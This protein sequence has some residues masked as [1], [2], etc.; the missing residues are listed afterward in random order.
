LLPATV[1]SSSSP[2][3]VGAVSCVPL[4]GRRD[5]S[6]STARAAPMEDMLLRLYVVGFCGVT[7]GTVVTLYGSR[8][9]WYQKKALVE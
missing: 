1:T 2:V 6:M 3:A 4:G 7:T 5:M 8:R 9:H